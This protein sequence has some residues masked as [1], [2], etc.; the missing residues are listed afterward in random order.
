[1]KRSVLRLSVFLASSLLILV[2]AGCGTTMYHTGKSAFERGD[3][4]A[5]ISSL[6][7][8]VAEEPEKAVLWR[9][10]GLAYYKTE[11][12]EKAI[13]ALKQATLL[14][15][16]DG[17]SV[18]YLGLSNEVSGNETEAVE[19][20][21]A[22]LLANPEHELA[23]RVKRRVRYLSDAKLRNEVKAIIESENE[24]DAD[25]IPAN[26][27]GVLGFR[28]EGVDPQYAVLGRGLAEVLTTDLAKV[29][30][31]TVVERMRLNEVRKELELSQSDLVEKQSAPRFGRLIGA[32]TVV[33]GELDQPKPEDLHATAGLISTAQGMVAYPDEVGG[34]LKHFFTLE[35]DLLYNILD[36]MGYTPTD[37]ERER[38]DSIPT[39]SLL[40]F[41]AYSRGLEYADQG[42]NNLAE[43]EF[44]AAMQEDPS[45]REAAEALQD[46]SGLGDYT[47]SVEPPRQFES[48]LYEFADLQTPEQESG[49]GLRVTGSVV[50]FHADETLPREGDN[51]KVYPQVRGGVTVTGTFHPDEP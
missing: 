24:I 11:R 29:S 36:E 33:T 19:T 26:S 12:Y 8:A 20:Y 37:D 5:A 9:Q 34:K 49:A 48:E 50:G 27:V 39:T 32:S 13:D 25:T 28:T 15:P 18:L 14:D 43:A 4:A 30:S 17:I 42:L 38:L 7:K 44:R 21:R 47:G 31:L 16:D 40:A 2:I 3:Y 6:E 35:K 51:P 41:L 23:V 1:M 22:F 10:L 45:F 46:I